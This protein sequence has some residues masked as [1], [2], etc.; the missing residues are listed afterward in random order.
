MTER[1]VF[2][3][4]LV[5]AI[6]LFLLLGAYLSRKSFQKDEKAKKKSKRGRTQVGAVCCPLC[7]SPLLKGEDLFSRVYRPMTVS[8]QRCTINGCPH[9]YPVSEAGLR[10]KKRCKIALL[11]QSVYFFSK[12]LQVGRAVLYCKLIFAFCF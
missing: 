2:I 3:L 6:L 8:D 5:L 12:L 4:L 11:L 9:C 1:F 7:K 10:W